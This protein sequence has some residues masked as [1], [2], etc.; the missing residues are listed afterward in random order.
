[1]GE[2]RRISSSMARAVLGVGLR[3]K[4]INGKAQD[5]SL[6]EFLS[7]WDTIRILRLKRGKGPMKTTAGRNAHCHQDIPLG[8]RPKPL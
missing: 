5:T 6:G 7:E 4:T 2:M 1:M 3:V 8:G